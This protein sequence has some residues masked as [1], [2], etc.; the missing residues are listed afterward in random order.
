MIEAA[1]VIGDERGTDFNDKAGGLLD[2]GIHKA[3]K[4]FSIK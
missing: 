3:A 4:L 1:P 2:Y